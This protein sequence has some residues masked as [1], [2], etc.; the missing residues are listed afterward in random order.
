MPCNKTR[1]RWK[2]CLYIANLPIL[3]FFGPLNAAQKE[4][5]KLC[6]RWPQAVGLVQVQIQTS[7]RKMA[8]V[9][10]I[11]QPARAG[12]VILHL[13]PI[14]LPLSPIRFGCM[15]LHLSP[16]CLPLSPI[17]CRCV[18]RII[19]H[20]FWGRQVGDKFEFMRPLM[21]RRLDKCKIM[22]PKYPQVSGNNGRQI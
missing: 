6:K 19:F 16:S 10:K 21:H 15:I 7:G 13:S 4:N 5:V 14:Y 8:R 2:L 1:T 20:F 11:M 9:C 12:R 18:G 22:Q 17:S 3:T